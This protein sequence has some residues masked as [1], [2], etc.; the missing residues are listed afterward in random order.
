MLDILFYVFFF[1]NKK[2]VNVFRHMAFAFLRHGML[3]V[4][5]EKQNAA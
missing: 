1:F 5:R 3:Y 2:L 4:K